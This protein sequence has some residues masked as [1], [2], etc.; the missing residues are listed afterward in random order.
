MPRIRQGLGVL[1]TPRWLTVLVV[2]SAGLAFSRNGPLHGTT[3]A[4]VLTVLFQVYLPGFLLARALG[5]HQIAQP[6]LR[7]AWI[8]ICGLSLTIILGAIARLFNLPVYVYLGGLHLVMLGLVWRAAGT[9]DPQHVDW[10]FQRHNLPLY[11]VVVAACLIGL[12][13]SYSS[14]YRFFGF[15]DQ[16]IFASQAGWIANNPGE[17]PFDRPLRARRI[18]AVNTVD[19]RF[20]TDGWTYNHAAWVWSSGVGASQLIWYELNQLFVWTV[21][22]IMFALAYE[23]T[24]RETA[25]AWAAASLTIVG[26]LTLDNLVHNPAYTAYGRFAVFQINVLRQA[27]VT[28]MLPLCLLVGLT[29]FRTRQRND[30][31][32]L[33][34]SGVALAIMHPILVMVLVLS[35]GITAVLNQWLGRRRW[36]PVSQPILLALII[37][38]TL[39]F[40]Q[41]QNRVGLSGTADSIIRTETVEGA[42]EIS[43]SGGFLLLP[44]V[45]LVGSTFIRNPAAVFYQ[46]IV[47]LVALLGLVYVLRIRHSLAAQYIVGTTVLF[48]LIAFLPGFTELF[49]RIASTVGLLTASFILPI[50]LILGLAL[51]AVLRRLPRYPVLLVAIGVVGMALILLFEPIPLTASPGDQLRAYNEMQASRRLL[52]T[53]QKLASRLND[54]LPA[55]QTSVLLAVPDTT[56]IIIEDLPRTL[57]TG[58]R[59]SSNNARH[60][61]NRFFNLAGFA[62]PWLDSAD[63]EFMAEYTVTHVVIRADETRAPQLALQPDRF[64]WMETV[65]GLE[66]YAWNPDFPA[67]NIDDLFMEMN[68][69]Y[70]ETIQPRWGPDGFALVRPGDNTRWQPLVTEWESLLADQPDN[71][72]IQLGT[73]F[74]YLLAGDDTA[75]LPLWEKLH[76][77]HPDVP[78]FT[79]ALAYTQHIL[80]QPAAGFAVLWDA[81]NHDQA[82]FRALA[83]DALLSD[84]FFYLLTPEQLDAV[85]A[86][87]DVPAW[88]YLVVFD[89]PDKMR[90]QATLLL[91]AQR[92]E[93]A[94]Q[95][96]D[97]IPAMMVSPRDVTAQAI[98]DLARGDI[99]G[100]LARLQPATEPDWR[101]AKASFQPDRWQSNHAARLYYLLRGDVAL[102]DGRALDAATFYQ[103]A[104]DAGATLPGLYFRA[105]ALERAGDI[106]AAAD[107]R[108]KLNAMWDQPTPFPEL[109]PL[110][111]I[112]ESGDPYVMQP[113]IIQDEATNT[114]TVSATYGNFQPHVGYPFEFW[115]YELIHPD[116]N[117]VYLTEDVPVQLIDNAL[118]RQSV[119]L[120]LPDDL[121]PLTSALLLV[122]AGHNNSVMSLPT[123]TPITLNRP[124]SASIP[125]TAT[126]LDL[127]FGDQITLA[128]Y[129]LDATADQVELTLFW[130][131][132]SRLPENYQIFVHILD[133][134]GTIITQNDT[135]PVQGRYPTSQ[136]R[137]NT[138][139]EDRHTISVPELPESF[140]L[141]L[142][143]YRLTDG[144]RLEINPVDD[145]IDNDSLL[146]EWS[147]S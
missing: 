127:Q 66:I 10:R 138:L 4:L 26:L 74:A 143:L 77:Q 130:Q 105:A 68:A 147:E 146:L 111:T 65:D 34:A 112:A 88:D 45:P 2:L 53:H 85:L 104:I 126:A 6:I 61:D 89:Q 32:M 133:A 17:T 25:A 27:A 141:R 37:M 136:W 11:I 16:V 115:R 58:G 129:T 91:L 29:Y 50:A 51:D 49:N 22:L 24:R 39:P 70:T 9:P 96:L 7:F 108:A 23:L 40:I 56:S 14:R 33:V 12:F 122:R 47:L 125:T 54:L 135:A 31:L 20:D 75:A 43:V 131:T 28:F 19:T 103:Q 57:I 99:E 97:S 3:V 78:L 35:I 107:L 90:Q 52:P 73:A 84:T 46:P 41:R 55:D 42:N 18:G 64:T 124:D 110:L 109:V 95:W 69:L 5:K 48:W 100:A 1:N 72:R 79:Q 116:T 106:P 145:R 38:L 60:G 137:T 98:A 119:M 8:I 101:A 120:S 86:V 114:L 59:G 83:A 140:S 118:V 134:T 87:S 121:E 71:S 144:T 82:A 76:R 117:M 132:D 94:A 81:L 67:T 30:W 139:I 63:L 92:W 13:V 15:E 102:R 44:E 36:L 142:G 113:T 93:A 80:G 62:A 123:I 128:S 21:P